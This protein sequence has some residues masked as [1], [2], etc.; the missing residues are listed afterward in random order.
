MGREGK[1]KGEGEEGIG[2]HKNDPSGRRSRGTNISSKNVVRTMKLAG[3]TLALRRTRT[4]NPQI[5]CT[6]YPP[7]QHLM[8]K[9]P[10]NHEPEFNYIIHISSASLALTR[11]PSPDQTP[12]VPFTLTSP[13]PFPISPSDADS[14]SYMQ[15][16]SPIFWITLLAYLALMLSSMT[17][18]WPR[19]RS[20]GW[21]CTRSAILVCCWLVEMGGMRAEGRGVRG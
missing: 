9:W 10:E 14:R 11:I 6:A 16:H 8:L 7:N 3:I 5:R 18:A 2:T 15:M 13:S 1:E 17:C 12:Y 21:I 4:A 19:S 20:D